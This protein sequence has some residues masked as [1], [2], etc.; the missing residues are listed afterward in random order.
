MMIYLAADHAGF[1]LKMS[2]LE[3]LAHHGYEVE[4]LGPSTLD[5]EDDYPNYAFKLTTK[6]LGSEDE[7]PRGILMCGTGQG[8]AIAA[9]RVAG[10]RTAL[11]WND[12]V[13]RLSRQDEDTNVLSLPSR[14]ID[15][16]TATKIVDVWLKTKFSKAPRHM[17]RLGEIENLYG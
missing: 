4:D 1:E 2:M 7:D 5:K 6:V 13:A 9:N 3:H 17:R 15:T 10:I 12:E 16:K 14:F 8:M 11:A